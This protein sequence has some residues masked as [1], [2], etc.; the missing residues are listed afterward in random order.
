VLAASHR[1]FRHHRR[2]YLSA[3][4]GL[5]PA[6]LVPTEGI[7][8]P[9]VLAS[10]TFFAAYLLSTATTAT[11]TPEA[12]RQRASYGDEGILLIVVLT[13]AAAASSLFAIFT[14]V[15]ASG[16]ESALRLALV[17]LNVIL[18]WTTLHTVL[19][20]HYGHRYYTPSGPEEERTDAGGLAFP[21]TKAPHL[22]DFLY[23]AFTV[24]MT[25]QTSDVEVAS[26]AMRRLTLVHGVVAFFYNTLILALAVNVAAGL[27]R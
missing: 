20:F 5:A 3:A 11:G 18:G 7:A 17:V 6:F 26:T 22:L 25:A 2:F 19:A 27:A 9:L 14:I 4:L 1:H 21:E 23:F 16:P 10:T 12:L 13:V 15:A 24:G 8:L